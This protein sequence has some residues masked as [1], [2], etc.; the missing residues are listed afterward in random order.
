M[1][2]VVPRH[3]F[4]LHCHAQRTAAAAAAGGPAA[5]AAP[6]PAA[7]S[8]AALVGLPDVAF[9]YG[10]LKCS[11]AEFVKQCGATLEEYEAFKAQL[12]EGPIQAPP[13]QPHK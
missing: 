9:P 10:H 7:H 13:K 1:R 11:D 8:S 3:R 5:A 4:F 12:F 2:R 6:A